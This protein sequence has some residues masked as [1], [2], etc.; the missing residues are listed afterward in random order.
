[1]Q[2]STAKRQPRKRKPQP[3]QDSKNSDVDHQPVIAV[4]VDDL[5]G[6]FTYKLVVVVI[7]IALNLQYKV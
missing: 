2:Q 3:P 7:L 4:A 1:M 5:V 6:E